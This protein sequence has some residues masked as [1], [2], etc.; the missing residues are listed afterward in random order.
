V[1]G[2]GVDVVVHSGAGVAMADMDPLEAS[3][4]MVM[5]VVEAVLVLGGLDWA[6]MQ[7]QLLV[8]PG[9]TSMKDAANLMWVLKKLVLQI[10][11]LMGNLQQRRLHHYL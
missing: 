1:T 7:D 3:E 2:T 6:T 4:V 9:H 11:P 8:G 10:V 5:V